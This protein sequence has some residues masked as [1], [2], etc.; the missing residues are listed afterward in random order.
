MVT[1]VSPIQDR[2]KSDRIQHY[3]QPAVRRAF[4]IGGHLIISG[5]LLDFSQLIECWYFAFLSYHALPLRTL[6]I[7]WVMVPIGQ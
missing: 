7:S 2:K 4:C 5:S 6:Q 1:H 3:G